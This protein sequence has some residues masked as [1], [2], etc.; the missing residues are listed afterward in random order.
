MN[1]GFGASLTVTGNAGGGLT[2]T[3][4]VTTL[5]YNT[6]AGGSEF[7]QMY[8]GFDSTTGATATFKF[9]SAVDAF[10]AYFTGTETGCPGAISVRFN[11]GTSESLALT[12]NSAGGVVFFGF[13]DPGVD[14][15][16]IAINTGATSSSQDIWG[17]DDVRFAA[18]PASVPEPG[19]LFLVGAALLALAQWGRKR[20]RG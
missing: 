20:V 19:T 15:V 5:G 8:P 10:G 6:T 17:I 4:G 1:L 13:A 2:K 7:L 3:A 9:A 12:K 14:I 18:T 11:D 16:S